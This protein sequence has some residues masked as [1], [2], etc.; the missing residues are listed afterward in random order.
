MRFL[1]YVLV[2]FCFLATLG[3]YEV[4]EEITINENGSGVYNTKMDMSQL[5][6]LMQT[7]GGEEKMAE[8]GLDRAIDTVVKFGMLFDDAK[9]LTA[10]QKELMKDGQMRMQLNV[11]EKLFKLDLN[12]PYKSFASLQKLLS[13]GGATGNMMSEMMKEMFGGKKDEGADSSASP[14]EI[15]GGNVDGLTSFY[16]VTVNKN[17]ISRKVNVEKHKALMEKPEMAQMKQL[18][19]SGMEILY[20]TVI[21]LPRPVKNSDNPIFKLSDDKKT[22]TM[23]YN[24]LEMLETPDK[25]SYTIEY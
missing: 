16:D 4:N 7:F 3:C 22:V 1:K 14:P 15:L 18:S 2:T 19:S 9:E 20:T 21:R 25:F 17:L 11:K 13:S 12:I 6:E 5:I 10:E 8:E 23:K 24:L